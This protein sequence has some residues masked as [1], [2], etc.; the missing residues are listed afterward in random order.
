M[1]AKAW[2]LPSHENGGAPLSNLRAHLIVFVGAAFSFIIGERLGA[3]LFTVI[4]A[5]TCGLSWLFARALFRADGANKVWPLVVVG[6]LYIFA[7]LSAMLSASQHGLAAQASQIAGNLYN[8]TGTATLVFGFLEVFSNYGAALSKTEKRFRLAY[9]GGYGGLVFATAIATKNIDALSGGAFTT[10]D[11]TVACAVMGVALAV[12]AV[13]FRDRHALD[14]STRKQ[15][16]APGPAARLAAQKAIR[17]IEQEKVYTQRD[18]K[19]GS[20]ADLIG[21]PE[22]RVSQGISSELGFANFNQLINHYRI[23][24]AAEL[25]SDPDQN[26]LP[27]LTIAM[28]CGFASIGPFNRAF[29]KEFGVTPTQY[30]KTA[31][32]EAPLDVCDK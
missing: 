19:V 14:L 32:G 4:G 8:F 6:A 23:N 16:Q 10:T 17:L 22:Y 11:V 7:V 25:L 20:V 18:L 13:A 9:A 28:D 29:K 26:A 12:M 15:K 24:H 2:T 3:T 21:E 31:Q 1:N 5:G 30:R 27:V